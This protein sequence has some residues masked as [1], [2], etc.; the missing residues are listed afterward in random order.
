MSEIKKNIQNNI[1][2]YRKRLNLTQKSLAS[3]VGVAAT[4]LASWEQGKSLPDIDTLF[5]LCDIFGI[6]IETICRNKKGQTDLFQTLNQSEPM[7]SPDE[8]KLIDDYRSLNEQGREH[9]RICMASAQALFKE[10]SADISNMEMKS[11]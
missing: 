11:S 6:D 9:I 8:Q 1:A 5:A 10:N 4:S 2:L 3:Q 7:Y